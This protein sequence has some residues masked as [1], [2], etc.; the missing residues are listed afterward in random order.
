M[1]D[2][3]GLTRQIAF[4]AYYVDYIFFESSDEIN[5]KD[6]SLDFAA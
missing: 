6:F 1:K 4:N 3:C 2:L 5:I